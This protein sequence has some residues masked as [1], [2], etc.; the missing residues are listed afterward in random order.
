[1]IWSEGLEKKMKLKRTYFG[2]KGE[3]TTKA[4]RAKM[5]WKISENLVGLK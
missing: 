1:M 3:T 2:K 4:N 5:E